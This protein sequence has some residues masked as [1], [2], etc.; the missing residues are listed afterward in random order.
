M[1]RWVL[2][3]AE[4]PSSTRGSPAS[5]HAPDA[6]CKGGRGQV[7]QHVRVKVLE[8]F[9]A[10]EAGLVDAADPAAGV[11]VVALGGEDFGE[12][13]L[14]GQAFSGCCLGDPGMFVADGG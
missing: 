10:R 9:G 2:P 13:C 11:A 8:A 14:V 4:S 6:R 12:E 1:N 3:A 5:I 7:G